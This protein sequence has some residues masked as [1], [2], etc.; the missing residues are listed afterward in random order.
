MGMVKSAWMEAEER[1]WDA[2]EKNVCGDCVSDAYLKALIEKAADAGACDYCGEQADTE[3]AAPVE[4]VMSAVMGALSHYF[5]EPA[6]A[7]VPYESAEGGWLIEPMDT[8]DALMSLP[9]ECNE[10]L[11][12][13]IVAAIASFNDAWVRAA[14]GHWASE[15]KHRL[16]IHSWERFAEHV[17]HRQRYFFTETGS[18]YGQDIAPSQLMPA[19]ADIV[20]ELELIQQMGMDTPLFRVRARFPNDTWLLVAESLGAPPLEKATAG[21]MNP[22]GISYLYLALEPTTAAAEVVRG[23]P[24][25]LAL[26]HFQAT[27]PLT[28]LNLNDLPEL[29]SI[30]DHE[31]LQERESLVFLD[32][33]V[34]AISQ[35][36][37]KDGGEH[38]EYIPSQ[39]VC[40]YFAS[41]FQYDTPLD[42]FLYPSAVSKGGCNLV[43]FP[44]N[45]EGE[46]RFP[47]VMFVKSW[48][49][50]AKDWDTLC[51]LIG[52]SLKAS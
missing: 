40:E 23:P 45:D 6:G 14:S 16:L 28:L 34:R 52:R 21:R 49:A 32:S 3:I 44:R 13:D 18:E 4:E 7:G 22:P 48:E 27:R 46:N 39:V 36:V 26:G 9:L 35:P 31:R 47:Q 2:P 11:F 50:T 1:G 51:R 33:F 29:P 25:S 8:A 5:A 42:G 17:K 37:E 43:L 41:V 12:H 24:C 38:V 10:D 20:S 30:F 19:L 15:Q